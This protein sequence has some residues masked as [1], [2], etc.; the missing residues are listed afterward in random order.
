MVKFRL[1]CRVW[2]RL[3]VESETLS[4][5]CTREQLSQSLQGLISSNLS[6]YCEIT[7]ALISFY[8][9]SD[10]IT[11]KQFLVNTVVD[12][13]TVLKMLQTNAHK[14]RLKNWGLSHSEYVSVM[15]PGL[16]WLMKAVARSFKIK[17]F[18]ANLRVF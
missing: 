15:P 7:N 8:H 1:Y 18:L 13:I 16:D 14:E 6:F 2:H 9:L 3:L 4:Y 11:D 17:V 12:Q 5:R 10:V